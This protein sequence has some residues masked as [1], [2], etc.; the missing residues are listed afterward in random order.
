MDMKYLTTIVY[1]GDR[2][3]G[4]AL[5]IPTR[6]LFEPGVPIGVDSRHAKSIP[7]EGFEYYN[8]DNPDHQ[9]RGKPI[10]VTLPA[11]VPETCAALYTVKMLMQQFPTK[12][13]DLLIPA[14]KLHELVNVL[15]LDL[16]RIQVVDMVE[17]KHNKYW[18]EI[19]IR[20]TQD[21]PYFTTQF[22]GHCLE[23]CYS[24]V[25]K[26]ISADPRKPPLIATSNRERPG[27]I[28]GPNTFDPQCD[29]L[30]KFIGDLLPSAL[31][32][33]TGHTYIHAA[34]MLRN[35]AYFIA[36]GNSA[37]TP[38]AVRLGVPTFEF[39]GNIEDAKS[40]RHVYQLMYFNQT[41]ERLYRY[42]PVPPVTESLEG[43]A[44]KAVDLIVYG[45]QSAEVVREKLPTPPLKERVG[46]AVKRA[47][48]S[49]NRPA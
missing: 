44:R 25:V 33:S 39:T 31:R 10:L 49:A 45:K 6:I 41:K 5:D 15:E 26:T 20:I 32:L 17:K 13:F 9:K 18:K 16:S 43:L 40:K 8:P 22:Q 12:Q 19:E 1:A 11:S 21:M 7:R 4:V 30:F 24:N 27:V 36:V 47:Q 3:R 46:E 37:I 2:P 48:R 38:V 29:A 14:K 28:M 34:E 23:F 35:A 42:T